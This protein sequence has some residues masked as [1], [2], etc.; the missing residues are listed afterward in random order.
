VSTAYDT[1]GDF[2]ISHVPTVISENELTRIIDRKTGTVTFICRHY[3]TG[4]VTMTT[5]QI[6]DRPASLGGLGGPC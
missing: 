5:T 1:N 4:R 3:E 6:Q 2:E